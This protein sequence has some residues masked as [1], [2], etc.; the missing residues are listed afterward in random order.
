MD[1]PD[2]KAQ[3][4][5]SDER[6]RELRFDIGFILKRVVTWPRYRKQMDDVTERSIAG[7]IV[8][9]LKMRNW[10]F[11]KGP[12]TPWHSSPSNSREPEC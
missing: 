4:A 7:E 9:K 2:R 12:P 5:A 10:C 11:T 8:E 6:E 1:A 3:S